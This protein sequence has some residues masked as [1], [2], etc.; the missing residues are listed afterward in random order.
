MDSLWRLYFAFPFLFTE[1]KINIY[2][3]IHCKN[4]MEA[5]IQSNV[6][7]SNWMALWKYDSNRYNCFAFEKCK[8][9]DQ[10]GES[11]FHFKCI[12][13]EN[14]YRGTKVKLIAVSM[15]SILMTFYESVGVKVGTVD[16]ISSYQ[17]RCW[18]FTPDWLLY[19]I[20]INALYQF[21]QVHFCK[22]M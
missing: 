5:H 21:L 19:V 22:C 8:G 14:N 1:F 17:H 11:S 20:S 3:E 2:S 10:S 18:Y 16:V 7:L 4:K 15:C 6:V 9:H 13:F 12:P